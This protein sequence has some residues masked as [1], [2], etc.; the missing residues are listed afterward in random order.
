MSGI[1]IAGDL[2]RKVSRVALMVGGFG[3]R[4]WLSE[5][6]RQAGADVML[7]GEMLD[8]TA[9]AARE[10]DIAVIK[11]SH[12]ATE[13]PA[14]IHFAE[15]LRTLVKDEL[16]VI[17]LPSGD[18]WEHFGGGERTSARAESSGCNTRLS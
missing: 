13:N 10:A 18:S 14:V 5:F 4:L 11:A 2:D 16:E 3:V 6:A 9:R 12:Y 15:H 17:Y 1:D 7:V 8:Y